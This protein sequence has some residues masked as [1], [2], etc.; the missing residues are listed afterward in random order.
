MNT[1]EKKHYGQPFRKKYGILD[2]NVYSGKI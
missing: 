2:L 1:T